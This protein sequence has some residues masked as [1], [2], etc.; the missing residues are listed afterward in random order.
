MGPGPD[1]SGPNAA[2]IIANEHCFD[3]F[4]QFV[5][6]T[7]KARDKNSSVSQF[8]SAVDAVVAGDLPRLQSL[9]RKKSSLVHTRSLRRHHAT[10]LHYVGANGVE[11]FRQR[12]PQNAVTIAETLLKA[13]AQV[14]ATAEIYGKSTPLDLVATSIHPWRAGVQQALLRTL[15]QAQS[16]T[17]RG[18]R[19]CTLI[20][21]A[22]QNGRGEAAEFLAA[23]GAELNLEAAAGVGRLDVVKQCFDATGAR[24]GNVSAEKLRSAFRWACQYG[25]TPVVEFLMNKVDADTLK[26]GLHWAIFSGNVETLQLFLRRNVPLDTLNEWGGTPLSG[27]VWCATHSHGSDYA[28]MIRALISAGASADA[29]SELQTQ[30]DRILGS[31]C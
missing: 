1:Y 4:A 27:A 22:L 25:R 23:Q 13:G 6:F 31:S 28:P 9:L 14:D 29:D 10:L 26:A 21:A 17:S 5:E 18:V 8:E 24:K 2:S 15:L 7:A 12:T 11:G 3:T 19:S 16:E 20:I 30:I